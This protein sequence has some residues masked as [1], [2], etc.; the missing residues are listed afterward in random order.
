MIEGIFHFV[1]N[2]GEFERWCFEYWGDGFF[3][4]LHNTCC[5]ADYVENF[6]EDEKSLKVK[7]AIIQE[8]KDAGM[9]F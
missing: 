8:L 6:N 2:D 7:E 3:K 5:N 4:E 9:N 1:N